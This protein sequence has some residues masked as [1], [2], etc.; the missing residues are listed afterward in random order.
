M[1]RVFTILGDNNNDSSTNANTNTNTF[2]DQLCQ[3]LSHRQFVL[4]LISIIFILP[5]CIPRDVSAL[6]RLSAFSVFTKLLLVF[7]VIFEFFS[8]TK[9]LNSNNNNNWETIKININ[10]F[11]SNGLSQAIGIFA[12]SFVAHDTAFLIYNTL[13]QP[14]IK[15][16]SLLN[17]YGISTAVFICI[18]FGIPGYLT[19]VTEKQVSSNILNSYPTHSI[20]MIVMRIIY[21]FSMAFSFPITF[22]VVRHCLFVFFQLIMSPS[23]S[24]TSSNNNK[25]I[26][27]DEN[28]NEN[29]IH[30]SIQNAPLWKHLLMTFLLFIS[31]L[32]I[33]LV[34]DSLGMVMSLVGSIACVN[35]GFVLPCACYLKISPYKIAFWKENTYDKSILSLKNIFVPVI[36]IIVGIFLAVYTTI[37]TL[38]NTNNES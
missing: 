6:E 16:W 4:T 10:Y 3:L 13:Y 28:E 15:R 24:S 17:T 21:S 31:V 19:F 27:N 37:D 30:E 8:L 9:V 12:F 23:P 34:V 20:I 26:I 33:A 14:T 36:L 29:E 35:L 5:A 22:Y 38:T 2:G 1:T 32:L 7:V 18:L 11:D 25:E